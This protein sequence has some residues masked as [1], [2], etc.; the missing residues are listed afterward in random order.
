MRMVVSGSGGAVRAGPREDYRKAVQSP[1]SGTLAP[2]RARAS[3]TFR[4]MFARLR[5]FTRWHIESPLLGLMVRPDAGMPAIEMIDGWPTPIAAISAGDIVYSGGVGE[6]LGLETALAD[7]HGA[8]V[9]AFDPTPRSIRYVEKV[10]FNGPRRTFVP[11]GLW[12]TD[13]TLR[14][15]A[16]RDDRHVSHSVTQTQGG[17][18]FFDAPCRSLP[19]VMKDLGHDHIDVLKLNI[20]GAEDEV[21]RAMLAAGIKPRVLMISWEGKRA[22]GKARS[23]TRRLRDEGYGMAGR[24]TWSCAYVRRA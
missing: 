3:G 20:E 21:L 7:R 12:S 8:S 9:W 19:S 23:F 14:F 13:T 2:P 4:R 16:P 6:D 1:V 17:S 24:S 18:G 11:V 10:G 5:E 15:H 22:L